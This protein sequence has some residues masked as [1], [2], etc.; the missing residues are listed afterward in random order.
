MNPPAHSITPRPSK[1]GQLLVE[2]NQEEHVSLI[3]VTTARELAQRM[4]RVMELRDGQLV[5]DEEEH[6]A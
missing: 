2:L 1:L 3:V 5:S 4:G 6:R